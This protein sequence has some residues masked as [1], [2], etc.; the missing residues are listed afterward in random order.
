MTRERRSS[1]T[2]RKSF[3]K[4]A[5]ARKA[6]TTI[7]PFLPVVVVAINSSFQLSELYSLAGEQSTRLKRSNP[8][9]EL[10][11]RYPLRYVRFRGGSFIRLTT[12]FSTP[13]SE[14]TCKI[15]QNSV[16][17]GTLA[18]RCARFLEFSSEG[19]MAEREGFEPPIPFRVCALSR[20]VPSAT[21]PSQIGR[22]S[23]FSRC[24][25]L[26]ELSGF[27]FHFAKLASELEM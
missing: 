2:R 16:G 5:R 10:N 25:V 7:V 20:R 6:E 22:R 9:A 11:P 4:F 15:V 23:H 14:F 21:R 19:M 1:S 17:G 24:A 12:V 26:D 3:P 18:Q 13:G 27:V 8:E